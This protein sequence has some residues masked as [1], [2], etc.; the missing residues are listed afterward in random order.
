MRIATYPYRAFYDYPEDINYLA[1]V[2]KNTSENGELL[3][4]ILRN[5]LK[6]NKMF[7]SKENLQENQLKEHQQIADSNSKEDLFLHFGLLESSSRFSMEMEVLETQ[8][9]QKIKSYLRTTYFA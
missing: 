1:A 4:H 6:Y 5:C 7:L 9:L 8:E 2:I 3:V